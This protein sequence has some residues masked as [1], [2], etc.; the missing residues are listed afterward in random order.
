M[1]Q[2]QQSPGCENY[3]VCTILLKR[4]S[5]QARA[6]GCAE[7]LLVVKNGSKYGTALVYAIVTDS[8]GAI[9]VKSAP[10]RFD[11]VVT[12]EAMPG[13]T[14]TGLARVLRRH[15]PNLPIV[16]LSGYT[17]AIQTQQALAAVGS[18]ETKHIPTGRRLFEL[19]FELSSRRAIVTH[20]ESAN[21]RTESSFATPRLS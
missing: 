2:L 20:L 5:A 18:P 12:D 10:E 8:G 6:P 3:C 9:D 11:V 13:L 16:L 21:T 7:P 1:M 19:H 4:S 17:G 15:R 14:G